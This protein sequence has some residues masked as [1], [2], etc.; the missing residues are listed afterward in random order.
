[1][2]VDVDNFSRWWKFRWCWRS[3]LFSSVQCVRERQDVCA[4][5]FTKHVI[6]PVT[7]RSQA[8]VAVGIRQHPS[9]CGSSRRSGSRPPHDVECQTS[10][11]P[12]SSHAKMWFFTPLLQ[13][14]QV[15]HSM[16]LVIMYAQ[17]A[18]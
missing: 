7:S 14:L 5:R 13:L 10:I 6:S 8:L 2:D 18:A 16:A 15:E 17:Q 12:V 1:M 11:T 9:S 4:H 3:L